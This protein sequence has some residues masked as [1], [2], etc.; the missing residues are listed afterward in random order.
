MSSS[1]EDS[2]NDDDEIDFYVPRRALQ[3]QLAP[4]P[5]LETLLPT[6]LDRATAVRNENPFFSPS[7]WLRFAGSVN[8]SRPLLGREVQR[9]S[10]YLGRLANIIK[11]SLSL[12]ENG[13]NKQTYSRQ[14]TCGG[15]VDMFK[16]DFVELVLPTLRK[17]G[18]VNNAGSKIIV[19]FRCLESI[20]Q[21]FGT[22]IATLQGA[23]N[24]SAPIPVYIIR[25]RFDSR[26]VLW[27]KLIGLHK[28]PQEMTDEEVG[29][30]ARVLKVRKCGTT[31]YAYVLLCDARYT[32]SNTT[33]GTAFDNLRYRHY[34]SDTTFIDAVGGWV[35]LNYLTPKAR[36]RVF[37]NTHR[38]IS[39]M[40]LSLVP[41]V[42]TSTG[43][44][45]EVYTI[46]GGKFVK[47]VNK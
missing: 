37:F 5:V 39:T 19:T 8:F 13:F 17:A 30:P 6:L 9:A 47:L 38:P 2:S 45:V 41:T 20:V 12:N 43:R 22:G 14:L 25:K 32:V 44:I 15:S 21:T 40:S 1:S 3:T 46:E 31:H 42:I 34:I 7:W 35:P 18:V 10:A 26:D 27:E 29:W 36:M 23:K 4:P 24:A 28:Q 16:G 11:S 33:A